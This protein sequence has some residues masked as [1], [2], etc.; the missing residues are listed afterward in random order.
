M[1]NSGSN[2]LRLLRPLVHV[3]SLM[4]SAHPLNSSTSYRFVLFLS[5]SRPFIFSSTINNPLNI[6]SSQLL[7]IV[8]VCADIQKTFVAVCTGR[9][10]TDVLMISRY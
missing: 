6:L 8:P 2:L 5:V 1:R 7:I 3:K 10:Q 4:L 9:S